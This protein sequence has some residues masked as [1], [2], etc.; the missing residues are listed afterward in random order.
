[1]CPEVRQDKPGACPSCGMSLEPESLAVRRTEYTCPMHPEIV[2]NGP[3]SCPTCGMALEPRTVT[4]V[5]EDNPELRDMSRRFWVSLMLTLPLLAVAMASM[6]SEMPV[7]RILPGA[8]LPWAEFLLATPVVLWGGWPFLQRFWSSLVNRSPN[9]FTLIGMGTGVAFAYSVIA[10]VAPQL[11]PPSLRSMDGYPDVYFEAAAAITTLVLL[12]QV[13]EL[14]ARGRTSAAIRA[15]LDLSPKM[16]RR[17][18]PDGSEKDVALEHVTPGDRLRVRPG[19]K[20]PVDG[21]ILEGSSS[22]DESMISG[23]SI[24]IEK[25][26]GGN[27]IGATIN[28]T[29]SFVMRA[30]RVGDETLLARIVQLVSRAQRSRAPIQRLADRV[31]AWFVPLVMAVAIVTFVIWFLVGPQPRLAHALVNAVAVLII[32][33]PCALGLATP[34]AIMVGTGRAAHAGVL[35]KNAEALETLEKVDTL[36]VDKT[37]TLTEGKARVVSVVTLARESQPAQHQFEQ[38]RQSF[39]ENE[40]LQLA[41]SLERASEHPLASAIVA[42]AE[43]RGLRLS[44]VTG[45]N[46]L[47]GRG[48]TAM[49]DGQVIAAGNEQLLQDLGTAHGEVLPKAE[50]LRSQGQTVIFVLVEGKVAGLIGVADPIKASTPN[51][52]RNLRDQGIDVVMITGDHRLTAQA[53]ANQLGIDKFEAEVLPE[54]KVD[55]VR[56]LQG[57][58]R[59]VA[60]AGD[61][62]N[63]APALAQANI[64]IAM[65][66]G[67]DVAMESGGVTLVKGDLRG[68]VRARKLSQATMRNIRQNLFFAFIYNALG[69]P[70]A[71]GVLYPFLGLLLSPIFAAVAMSFSSVSVI[72]NALRLRTVKL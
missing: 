7:R 62:I 13:M 35:I 30:E 43:E 61:G 28:G 12:G 31:S 25:T 52:V 17:L 41:A 14:R 49:L 36:V 68:I 47:T 64:G 54:G 9:M 24:P 44:E 34:M 21:V 2:R 37:G 58:G 5:E 45:F 8:S 40:L 71:A 1:M 27:V 70:I 66:T 6:I 4:A 33:C 38:G 53:V 39:N 65:G 50:E 72:T 22:I 10:T 57:Q 23:E 48:V 56:R 46:S 32:A 59:V 42:A 15:L 60:M 29:G 18:N 63:D 19:E 55:V 51:A 16:A 69:V 26:V 11:F 20:V 3:G 67:T